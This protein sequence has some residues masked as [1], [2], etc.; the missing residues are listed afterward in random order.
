MVDKKNIWAIEFHVKQL[1]IALVS[2]HTS[3]AFAM[4]ASTLALLEQSLI[5]LLPTS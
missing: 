5:G 2:C 1:T 3:R 4:R